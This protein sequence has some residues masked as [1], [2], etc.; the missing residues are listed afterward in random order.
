MAGHILMLMPSVLQ[1][2][3]AISLSL[4]AHTAWVDGRRVR[5]VLPAVS[6]WLALILWDRRMLQTRVSVDNGRLPSCMHE[7]SHPFSGDMTMAES[8]SSL[9]RERYAALLLTVLRPPAAKSHPRHGHCGEQVWCCF[10][11]QCL[12]RQLQTDPLPAPCC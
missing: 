4:S 11:Q 8:K 2:G 5:P 7:H 12:V 3:L 10:Q 6:L 9:M 1:T